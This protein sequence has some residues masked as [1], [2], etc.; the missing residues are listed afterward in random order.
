MIIKIPLAKFA[1]TA[2]AVKTVWSSQ[3]YLGP[4]AAIAMVATQLQVHAANWCSFFF[5]LFSS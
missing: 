1:E 4:K 2:K 3:M 5:V